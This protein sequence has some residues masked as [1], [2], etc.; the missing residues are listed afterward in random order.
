MEGEG[1]DFGDPAAP[2]ASNEAGQGH[3]KMQPQGNDSGELVTVST[4][5]LTIHPHSQNSL[6]PKPILVLAPTRHPHPH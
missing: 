2:T 4:F 3:Q 6:H 1:L 5:T